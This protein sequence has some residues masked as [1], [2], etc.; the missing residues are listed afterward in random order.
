MIRYFKNPEIK[1]MLLKLSMLSIAIIALIIVIFNIEMNSLNK[2]YIEQNTL[3]VGNI[4]AKNPELEEEVMTSLS[5]KHRDNYNLGREVLSK[6]SYDENLAIYKNPSINSFYIKFLTKVIFMIL[7]FVSINFIMAANG[8]TGFYKQIEKFTIA[9]EKVIEGQFIN[10]NEYNKEGEIYLFAH[11]FNLMANRLK[12]S[13]DKL[14]KE[15]IFFKNII[16]DIS[17]QLKTPLFSLIMFNDLMKEEDISKEDRKNFLILSEE[18]LKRMQW[19]IINLL[20]IGRLEAGVINFKISENPLNLTI[21]KA[22]SG[23]VQKSEEK[24]QNIILKNSHEIYFNHDVE[25]TAEAL[26]NIIKNAIEHTEEG[27]TIAIETEE[28]PLSVSIIIRDNGVGIP[29]ELLGKIFERF[30][31][32]ENSINPTSLGIGLYLSKYIIERQN[33]SIRVESEV[34]K[35]A[36]FTMIFLKTII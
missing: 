10:F 35:G 13:M 19:L 24:N 18:Q 27:G 15:K 4:L 22:L 8:F 21:Y 32:G 30:Y 9:A 26:S 6:Y 16:S 5:L 7:I 36:K 1:Y 31:K 12:E 28:T 34:D 14:K 20:K 17:H 2:K 3:I 33:G 11:Q 23:L 29:E 25:W